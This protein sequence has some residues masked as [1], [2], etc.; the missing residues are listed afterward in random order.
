MSWRYDCLRGLMNM[1]PNIRNIV[2]LLLQ[3]GHETRHLILQNL[4]LRGGRLFHLYIESRNAAG[5][6]ERDVLAFPDVNL[7]AGRFVASSFF[8][9]GCDDRSGFG[10]RDRGSILREESLSSPSGT[11][12]GAQLRGASHSHGWCFVASFLVGI[13]SRWVFWRGSRYH[14]T[15]LALQECQQIA[16]MLP[17]EV[18]DRHVSNGPGKLDE[19]RRKKLFLFQFAVLQIGLEKGDYLVV[20]FLQS[21]DHE[22]DVIGV[23]AVDLARRRRRR[24]RIGFSS[25]RRIGKVSEDLA[26]GGLSPVVATGTLC[27][28]GEW[29]SRHLAFSLVYNLDCRVYDSICFV[30]FCFVSIKSQAKNCL[31]SHY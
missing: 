4:E 26:L 6:V 27:C 9:H 7:D 22:L 10:S 25:A 19:A 3:L 8:A 2:N 5:V 12:N 30:S 1:K 23:A 24:R 13:N 17:I 20:F 18:P 16:G 11:E 29:R 14:N 21:V 15:V 28:L 31:V